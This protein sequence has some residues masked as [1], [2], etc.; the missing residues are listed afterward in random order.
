[1]SK[2]KKDGQEKQWKEGLEK[3]EKKKRE[4]E[5]DRHVQ[6]YKCSEIESKYIEELEWRGKEER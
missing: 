3:K 2:T 4:D 5:M 6:M 1:M